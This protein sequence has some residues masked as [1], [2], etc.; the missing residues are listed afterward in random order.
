MTTTYPTEKTAIKMGVYFAT[1]SRDGEPTFVEEQEMT[2]A[3][4][5]MM[6]EM[7]KHFGDQPVKKVKVYEIVNSKGGKAQFAVGPFRDGYELWLI[8]PGGMMLRT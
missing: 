5:E 8:G 2:T 1:G 4:S 3:L 6:P 7:A